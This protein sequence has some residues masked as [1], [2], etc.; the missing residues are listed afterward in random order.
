MSLVREPVE[1]DT[2]DNTPADPQSI[3]G[4][5]STQDAPLSE[6]NKGWGCQTIGAKAQNR[7]GS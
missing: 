3:V 2:N 5:Q 4:Y 7:D 6:K 1:G